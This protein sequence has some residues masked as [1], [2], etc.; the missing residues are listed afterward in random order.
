MKDI[1]FLIDDHGRTQSWSTQR[2]GGQF[3]FFSSS[4]FTTRSFTTMNCPHG[5]VRRKGAWMGLLDLRRL[6]PRLGIILNAPLLTGMG[7]IKEITASSTQFTSGWSNGARQGQILTD[8][9]W[10]HFVG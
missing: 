6:T 3:F 5:Y 9:H 1:Q 7:K 8:F 2:S 4:D 10:R